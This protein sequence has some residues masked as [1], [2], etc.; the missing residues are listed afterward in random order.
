MYYTIKR[1]IDLRRKKEMIINDLKNQLEVLNNVRDKYIELKDKLERRDTDYFTSSVFQTLQLDIY[2]SVFK[3]EL[4]SIFKSK[5]FT[6]VEIYKS[7]EFLKI[8]SPYNVYSDYLEKSESHF[9]EK[10]NDPNH[11]KYCETELGFIENT[12]K[13]INNHLNTINSIKDNMKILNK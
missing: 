6:L 12:I 4:Y 9:E 3:N 10:K 11:E 5:M 8:H 1:E 13:N 2:N 7:I